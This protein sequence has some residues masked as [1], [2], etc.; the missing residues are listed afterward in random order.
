MLNDSRLGGGG[1]VDRYARNH[2]NE[3][4]QRDGADQPAV[5]DHRAVGEA[6]G[7]LDGIDGRHAAAEARVEALEERL[8]IRLEPAAGR[9]S[10]AGD[11]VGLGIA[12]SE[13][14][15]QQLIQ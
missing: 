4:R 3:V 6:N 7:P 10:K 1:D 13:R 14:A 12:L 15:A 9:V 8:E 11:V 2:G 5:G